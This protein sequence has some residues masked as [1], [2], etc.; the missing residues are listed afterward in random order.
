MC[1]WTDRHTHT[2]IP[3]VFVSRELCLFAR[4]PTALLDS[5]MLYPEAVPKYHQPPTK[6]DWHKNH[7]PQNPTYPKEK[8]QIY[9]NIQ[10]PNFS[11]PNNHRPQ[12]VPA[13]TTWTAAPAAPLASK[14]TWPLPTAAPLSVALLS[15]A[16]ASR[17]ARCAGRSP[18][19]PLE[20]WWF[21]GKSTGNP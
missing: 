6:T 5:K 18:G 21:K 7:Q 12:P 13:S 2:H 8:C 1:A 4:R 10:P 16:R 17:A 9:P 11:H 20:M 19:V 15:R 3:S 14:V